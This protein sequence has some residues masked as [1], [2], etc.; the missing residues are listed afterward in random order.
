MN[1]KVV[2]GMSGGVDSSVAACLLQEAGFEVT[3]VTFRFWAECEARAAAA[4]RTCC[5]LA[6]LRDAALVARSL[7]IEHQ[8]VDLR[9]EFK[10]GVVDPFVDSYTAGYT[11]N[12]CVECNRLLKFPGLTRAADRLGAGRIATG[13]YA[14]VTGEGGRFRL[15]R[16]TDPAKDQ[17]Y[18]LYR[19][20]QP[21]L[22]RLVFPVGGRLK[23]EVVEKARGLGLEAAGREE[24]QDIC[25]LPDGDYRDFLRERRPEAF[26][27]GFILDRGG[28]ILGKHSGIA[29]FTI[30]QRRGLGVPAPH[31][32]YVVELDP[33]RNA[34]V[35]GPREEVDMREVRVEGASWIAGSPPAEEFEAEMKV[36]Y[37][38]E[39]VP[40]RVRLTGEGLFEAELGCPVP[41]AAPGQSAVL[42][43]G[44]EVLGGG[45]IARRKP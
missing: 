17:A 33:V 3:G 28:R 8:V 45:I 42:Y 30:G 1:E 32:L 22:A 25:F 34:V 11:P 41:A 19:L 15:L 7:G 2:L 18:V 12:P 44:D 6:D 43:R 9:R 35:V 40:A 14:R 23:R 21:T 29:D 16:G 5:S 26:L 13:H 4:R 24:S 31:P 36:R 37:Q 39:A 38:M 10:E 27:S 20:D